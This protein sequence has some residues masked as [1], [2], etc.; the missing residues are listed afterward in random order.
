MAIIVSDNASTDHTEDVVREV[1]DSRVRYVNTGTRVS[2][3]H[4]FEFAL[5]QVED[6]WVTFL[7]DDDGLLPGALDRVNTAIHET[8]CAAVT[9]DVL[10]PL[11]EAKSARGGSR[12]IALSSPWSRL[13][14]ANVSRLVEATAER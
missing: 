1:A 12:A 13:P 6:G 3:S 2:M 8:G 5:S 11:A 9:S 4:N 7:G 10:L 14:G